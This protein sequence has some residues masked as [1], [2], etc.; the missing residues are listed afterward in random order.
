LALH[1][2]GRSGEALSILDRSTTTDDA[3]SLLLRARLSISLSPSRAIV[4]LG[5]PRFEYCASQC[6]AE[7]AMLRGR[8]H[9]RLREYDTAERCFA[10]AHSLLRGGVADGELYRDIELSI[11]SLL[12][13]QS[14]IDEA[15]NIADALSGQ[16]KPPSQA[17]ASFILLAQVA[18]HREQLD[19]NAGLLLQ[20][21]RSITTEA[22][23]RLAV[24]SQFVASPA[25]RQAVTQHAAV[26]PWTDELA[27]LHSQV[28]RLLG[29]RAVVDGEI[30]EGLALLKCSSTT[31]GASLHHRI[32]ALLTHA[33]VSKWLDEPFS[34]EEYLLESTALAQQVDWRT[35]PAAAREILLQLAQMHARRDSALALSFAAHFD[36]LGGFGIDNAGCGELAVAQRNHCIGALYVEIG[37]ES[38]GVGMLEAAY[39]GFRR[40]GFDWP[41]GQTAIVLAEHTNSTIW[42]SRARE[43]LARYP[44]SFLNKRLA[45]LDR[46]DAAATNSVPNRR[47]AD[48]KWNLLTATQR[49][50]YFR[51]LDS[52]S[53]KEIAADLDRSDHTIRNHVQAIF[54]KFEVNSR[55]DLVRAYREIA[56]AARFQSR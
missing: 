35:A 40:A 3:S 26:L 42:R 18:W 31:P 51:L 36:S 2:R 20:A 41:A 17:A 25:V 30:T 13:A 32:D 27:D 5:H 43:C 6:Q 44:H 9:A 53:V 34:F 46:M 22:L 52:V 10:S 39:A 45:Q 4:I 28:N 56:G 19:K 29:T 54:R 23:K 50:V 33:D 37:E 48:P 21:L 8:A 47:P 15:A 11:G 49:T 12:I 1:R 14:R 38:K 7:A 55:A 24:V 16:E